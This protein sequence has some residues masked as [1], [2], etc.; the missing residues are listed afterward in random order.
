M[1]KLIFVLAL[2]LSCN[3][4]VFAEKI[5]KRIVEAETLKNGPSVVLAKLALDNANMARKVFFSKYLPN[6]ALGASGRWEI[7]GDTGLKTTSSTTKK[8]GGEGISWKR[9]PY[10]LSASVNIPLG[11]NTY[12][13][14]RDNLDDSKMDKL[15]YK[16]SI[17]DAIYDSNVLYLDLIT[18]YEEVAA[19]KR[20]LKRCIESRDL[21]KLKYNSGRAS[22]DCL[23]GEEDRL[24]QAKDGLEKVQKN[25]KEQSKKLLI[26]MGRS[27]ITTTLEIGEQI[28]IPKKMIKEPDYDRLIAKTTEFLKIK[29]AFEKTKANKTRINSN[30][31]PLPSVSLGGSY[32]P[33]MGDNWTAKNKSFSA[34]IGV[35][36]P[37]FTGF[38][39]YYDSKKASNDLQTASI[40]FS[41]QTY[42]L[43]KKAKELYDNLVNAF[44]ELKTATDK[45][46]SSEFHCEI[47][48][49]KF[50]NG[51]GK[52]ED[53]QMAEYNFTITQASLLTQK[54]QVAEK[55]ANWRR[56]AGDDYI[57]GEGE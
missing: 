1:R 39:R 22:I 46:T 44:K 27:N 45:L 28:I 24:L 31:L 13:E 10:S 42:D 53:W 8:N 48:K 21:I 43:K 3:L 33:D 47:E 30:W 6:V 19:A 12:N 26:A 50:I 34:T 18:A 14:I 11:F 35:S 17:L 5:N 41:K 16:K 52:Y 29:D 51:F 55:I 32:T 2:V 4:S 20:T 40:N 23:Q 54:K 56:F 25:A 36:Y 37:I 15:D 38:K 57:I 49:K 7:I 9:D